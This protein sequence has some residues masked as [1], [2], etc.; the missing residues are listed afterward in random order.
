MAIISIRLQGMSAIDGAQLCYNY[1]HPYFRGDIAYIDLDF[2]LLDAQ[3]AA[4]FSER[5]TTVINLLNTGKL[6]R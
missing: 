5:L 2:N 1:L 3:D 4:D 6:S